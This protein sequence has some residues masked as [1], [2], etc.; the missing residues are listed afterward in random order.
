MPIIYV[1]MLT[2]FSVLYITVLALLIK[3]YMN[4][5]LNYNKL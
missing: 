5:Y 1:H 2:K 3:A 4:I